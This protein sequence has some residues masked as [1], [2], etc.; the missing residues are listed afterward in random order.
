MRIVVFSPHLDDAALDV[1]DHITRWRL[2][3]HMVTIVSAFTAFGKVV[4][5]RDA[6][7]AVG[8]GNLTNGRFE[9]TRK[10]E[11]ELAMSDLGVSYVHLDFIDAAF[12]GRPLQL[13]F[14]S[15]ISPSDGLIVRK[16]S[17]IIKKYAADKHYVPLGVGGHIDHLILREAARRAL[18]DANTGYYVDYPYALQ[19]RN[20]SFGALVAFATKKK[21]THKNEQRK[22]EYVYEIFITNACFVCR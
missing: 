1:A 2:Q 4:I 11:D 19:M 17:G 12:R 3:G 14:N 18:G 10:N 13:V 7:R 8:M 6:R 5:P 20:W 22:M 16:L 21:V 15:G 9:R